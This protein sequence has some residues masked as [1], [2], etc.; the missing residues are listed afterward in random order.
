[1]NRPGRNNKGARAAAGRGPGPAS[2]GGLRERNRLDKLAR[3]KSAARDLFNE[4]GFDRATTRA[5]A[6]RAHVGL[7]TLFNYADDKRDLVFLIFNEEL[8]RI[9]DSAFASADARRPLAEQLASAFGVFYREFA[10][11][12][13]LS[14]ILLQE[15]TFY[16]HGR[17]AGDFQRS[18]RRTIGFIQQLIAAAQR[19]GRI[20]AGE[21]PATIAL[22]I[23]F[24]YSGAVRYWIAAAR[25]NP[26]KGIAELQRLLDIHLR[27][28]TA[29][30]PAPAARPKSR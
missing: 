1:V 6:E 30:R 19:E 23:F 7:G 3:I 4:L 18:K 11:N 25:P 22:S 14:R 2:P 26:G 9:T 27:G 10:A 17:L 21:D 24:L 28:V 29:P 13:T 12:P 20:H 16:S 8:D 5:I 15:L